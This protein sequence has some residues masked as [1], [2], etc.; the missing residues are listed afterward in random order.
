MIVFVIDT[1]VYCHFNGHSR[2]QAAL[3]T[4]DQL[5]T[6]TMIARKTNNITFRALY[7]RRHNKY[8]IAR[9]SNKMAFPRFPPAALPK[10]FPPL[11]PPLPRWQYGMF[12]SKPCCRRPRRVNK[13][14]QTTNRTNA[15]ARKVGRLCT[16]PLRTPLSFSSC[17][18]SSAMR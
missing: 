3:D 8:V 6:G 11:P 5:I 1:S 4:C 17:V 15:G 13:G 18:A 2:G 10:P 9:G 12:A 14:S 16:P 7:A